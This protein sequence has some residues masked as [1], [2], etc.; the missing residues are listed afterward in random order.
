MVCIHHA[1]ELKATDRRRREPARRSCHSTGKVDL[2]S[3]SDLYQRL[4]RH[5][6]TAAIVDDFYRRVLAD[7]DLQ[8]YFAG[9]SMPIQRRHMTAFLITAV[10]R[11]ETY[12][13]RDLSSAHRGL[14]VTG[15]D[16]E[17]IA[18]LLGQSL[19]EH[20]VAEEDVTT[21]LDRIAALR[22]QIVQADN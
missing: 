4:G 22:P 14:A 7:A 2:V 11:P 3:G 20:E 16:F 6:G 9:V 17:G 15:S 12:R 5:A 18:E 13:G 10:G 21:V 8:H 19:R 1:G